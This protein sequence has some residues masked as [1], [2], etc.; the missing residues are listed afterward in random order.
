MHY[1][2]AIRGGWLQEHL[3]HHAVVTSACRE[4][5][6]SRRHRR[7]SRWCLS[8]LQTHSSWAAAAPAARPRQETP[9]GPPCRPAASVGPRS[10]TADSFI[11][12]LRFWST[13]GY[14][15]LLSCLLSWSS[16]CA[17]IIMVE[18]FTDKHAFLT[19]FT[20]TQALRLRSLLEPS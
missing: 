9:C 20:K 5:S 12:L 16:C 18:V 14:K 6:P 4:P 1:L 10:V 17:V 19:L 7:H 3:P 15:Y 11:A 13:R 8:A 2:K